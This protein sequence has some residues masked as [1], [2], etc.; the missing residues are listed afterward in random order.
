LLAAL[1]YLLWRWLWP[2]LPW[3][4]SRWPAQ[5]AGAMGAMGMALVY[6]ALSGFAVPAQRALVMVVLAMCGL[7]WGRRIGHSHILVLALLLVVLVDPLAPLSPG[8][9]LSFSAVAIIL[10]GMDGRVATRGWW[11]RWGRVQFLLALGL[12][13][14]L[15]VLFA[16][17]P[18]V[19]PFVNII[20][21]PWVSVATVPLSLAGIAVSPVSS[22]VGGWL[23]DMAGLSLQGLWWLLQWFAQADFNLI[24]NQPADAWQLCFAIPAVLLLLAPPGLPT[25]WLGAVLLLPLLL[26]VHHSTLGDGDFRLNVLDVGQGLAAVV[27]TR[28]HVLVFDTGPRSGPDFDAGRAV[29]VPFLREH[30]WHGLDAVVVSHADSD[31]SGGLTSLLAEYHPDRLWLSAPEELI[32]PAGNFNA[33]LC[34]RGRGWQWDGVQFEFLHPPSLYRHSR[35]NR[36]CV[37]RVSSDEHAALLPGDLELA[38]ERDLATARPGSLR[39]DVLIAGHHGSRTSSGE[40]FVRRVQPHWVVY[41][42]GYRNRLHFPHH[43]VVQR[44]ASRQVRSLNTASD[45]AV[46][47]TITPD[48]IGPV[49]RY[50]Q[51][52]RHYWNA[53][54]VSDPRA[55][56]L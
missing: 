46:S 27:E 25:R 41:S 3:L 39:A 30:G 26:P 44:Y 36:S 42:S 10:Y 28:H 22:S 29:L 12:M 18:M 43:E 50:R 49:V 52:N 8:F 11:W 24:L 35:N 19:S 5:Y 4:G 34:R 23:L 32:L 53:A 6:A 40:D 14:L 37:L 7:L 51:Q 13:P 2:L 38:G 16:R 31:H 56:G 1:G 9:W 45:G 48:G 21:V 17:A 54:P 55:V 15:L 20:A 47:L 33:T